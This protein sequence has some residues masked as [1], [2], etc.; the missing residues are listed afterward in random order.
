MKKILLFVSLLT[1]GSSF[2]Q[3]CTKIFISEYVEGLGNNKALEIYN[4]T[5]APVDLSEYFIARYNN[6]TTAATVQNA[7][8]LTGTVPAYGTF[9]A[10][11]DRNAGNATATDPAVW[12]EMQALADGFFCSSYEVSNAM[13][14]NGD[15]AVLL[16]KGSINGLPLATELSTIANTTVYDVIGKVG[17]RPNGGWSTAAPYDGSAGAGVAITKDHSLIRKATILKGNTDA[18]PAFFSALAEWDS[19]PP[20]VYKFDALGDTI[21][22]AAGAPIRF[23]NWDSLGEHACNC[24]PLSTSVV[25]AV[26][27]EVYPNPSSN[28]AFTVNSTEN[29]QSITVYNTLGQVVKKSKPNSDNVSIQIGNSPG[30]YIVQIET[31]VGTAT[32]RLIVKN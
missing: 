2:A 17:E 16:I 9:V 24:N 32:K 18:L 3:D 12:D 22:S 29:I 21:K 14:F 28:G 8:Q 7:V 5:N 4:P 31:A 30:L 13:N 6:G 20:L 1:L 26:Q 23:G 11:I 15:D 25:E 19:L 27:M 10:V